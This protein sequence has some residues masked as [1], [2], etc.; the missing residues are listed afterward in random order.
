MLT[1]DVSF[2]SSSRPSSRGF[3]VAQLSGEW[4]TCLNM[5]G[6]VETMTLWFAVQLSWHYI[7]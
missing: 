1:E 2:P 4:L 5:T 7:R 3:T 6:I